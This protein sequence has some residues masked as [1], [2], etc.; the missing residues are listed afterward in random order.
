MKAFGVVAAY[1][2]GI[3]INQCRHH[4]LEHTDLYHKSLGL[5]VIKAIKKVP[6]L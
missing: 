5:G 6:K 3:D 4:S 1:N 2:A